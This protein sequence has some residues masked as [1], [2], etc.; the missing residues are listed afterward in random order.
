MIRPT[1]VARA[2]DHPETLPNIKSTSVAV[3][4]P[5]PAEEERRLLDDRLAPEELLHGET[6][7]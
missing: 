7:D 1:R 2:R 6:G 5:L 4:Y 3:V